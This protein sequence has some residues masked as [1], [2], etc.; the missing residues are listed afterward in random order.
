MFLRVLIFLAIALLLFLPFNWITVRQLL[1]IHLRRK[2]WIVGA[3]VAGNLMW[4]FF[5]LMRDF[6]TFS[7]VTH[8]IFGPSWW[9]W[10]CFAILYSGLL[11]L[12]LLAWIPFA[13]KKTFAEFAHGLR[14]CSSLPSS[15]GS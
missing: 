4:P 13:R 1:R 2:G 9:S 11:F 5:P 14:A 10:T 3:A 15:S 8:A 12:V 6:T 7:R